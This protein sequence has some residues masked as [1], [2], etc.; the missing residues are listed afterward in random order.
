MAYRD[1]I[2]ES[3][4]ET[5]RR[6]EAMWQDAKGGKKAAQGK[7]EDD[8]TR[9]ME[10][11]TKTSQ[12]GNHGTLA[13]SWPATHKIDRPIIPGGCNHTGTK[14]FTALSSGKRLYGAQA[15]Q[16]KA[17]SHLDLIVD[18]AGLL[19]G[20]KFIKSSTAPKYRSLNLAAWPDVITLS[21]PD[22]TAP[23]QVGIK[24]WERLIM[25]LPM[26]TAVCCMGGHGRTGTALAAMLVADG[27]G[28]VEAMAK[29]RGEH[30]TRAIETLE[31]ENY[32]KGL[33]MER[34][35]RSGKGGR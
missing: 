6:N 32:I 4:R 25:V 16:I 18:C 26:D 13:A 21:W 7:R 31:Q 5:R 30:C 22:M 11:D 33:E 28:A 12:T 34:N 29:V 2:W 14:L 35:T 23:T 24:F 27:M 15:H 20:K 1:G 10:A 19:Q 17:V 3:D 9:A 8:L